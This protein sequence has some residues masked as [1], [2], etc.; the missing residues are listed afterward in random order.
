MWF[1]LCKRVGIPFCIP[2]N[3]ISFFADQKKKNPEIHIPE[4]KKGLTVH[5]TLKNLK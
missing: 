1:G 5:Y 4:M 2:L 3:L